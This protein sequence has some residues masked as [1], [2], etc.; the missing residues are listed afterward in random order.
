MLVKE[1]HK[2]LVSVSVIGIREDEVINFNFG[3]PESYMHITPSWYHSLIPLPCFFGSLDSLVYL[4]PEW[5][6][7][8]SSVV[9]IDGN[10]I[11]TTPLVVYTSLLLLIYF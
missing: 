5:F 7:C 1:G 6:C 8:Q 9:Y 2:W 3:I 4:W 11:F 10:L